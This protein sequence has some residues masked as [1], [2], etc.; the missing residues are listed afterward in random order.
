MFNEQ[1][2]NRGIRCWALIGALSILVAAA[3]LRSEPAATVTVTGTHPDQETGPPSST[4]ESP[5]P[6]A[7][8]ATF[9]QRWIEGL[10]SQA[11]DFDD[12]DQAFWYVFSR[13]PDEVTVYPSENYYYFILYVNG[14]QYWGNIR[15]P[16]GRRDQGVLSFAY[17]E[18][19]EFPEVDGEGDSRAKL[20]TVA[21]GLRIEETNDFTYIVR[22]RG[23]S[24][25]FNL[26]RL[27]QSPPKRFSLGADE[28]FVE[29]T[30]DESGYQFF[31]LF[32]EKYSYFLW[33]LNEEEIVPDHLEPIAE[34]IVVGRRSGF[35][36]WIDRA[37]DD[38]KVLVAIRSASVRRNDYYDGPFDQLA[39]NYADQAKIS[40]YMERAFPGVRGRID[41]YGYYTDTP[42]STRVAISAY[43]TYH[44]RDEILQLMERAKA[45]EDPNHLI[46]HGGSGTAD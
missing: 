7:G 30:F 17:F 38:R 9:N 14:R 1:W 45:T 15:L 46:S 11:F 24:V 27:S 6:S 43:S 8:Y 22:Y 32:N 40:E 3:C 20:F 31:L 29:R 41:K 42:T 4:N 37:H 28:K 12:V 10:V 5:T 33:V 39:D 25:T 19:V 44:I 23:K 34:D 16:A 35:A 36:F 2:P 21:D 18:F 13:L 26:H